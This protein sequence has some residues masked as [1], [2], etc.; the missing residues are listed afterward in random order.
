MSDARH[1]GHR[2]DEIHG[3][4]VVLEPHD[5]VGAEPMVGGLRERL[6]GLFADQAELCHKINNPLTSLIG[7]AQI[8]RLKGGQDPTVAKATEVIEAS[9]KRVAELVRELSQKIHEGRTALD[10]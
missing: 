6:H 1:S 2:S 7:R 3:E 8:L 5:L 4:V 10:R 9:A